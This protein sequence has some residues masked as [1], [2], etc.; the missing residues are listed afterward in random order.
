MKLLIIGGTRF[1]GRHIVECA[2]SRGHEITLFHRGHT[3]KDLFD[4]ESII[5]DRDGETDKLDARKWD[6]VIDTCGYVPRV[7][8]Q[9]AFILED[10]VDLYCFI[11][12]ISVYAEGQPTPITE[13]GQLIRF[14]DPP[15]SE[16]VTNETYGGFKVLCE[17]AVSRIV[18]EDRT[19]IVRPGLIVGPHDPTDRFTYWIDRYSS[20]REILVPNRAQQPMQFVDARDLAEF[21]V[22]LVEQKATGTYN[23]T[24]PAHATT[25]GEVWSVCK[26]NAGGLPEEVIVSDEFLAENEVKEWQDLP[27]ITPLGGDLTIVDITKSINAGL[28]IRPMAET[29]AATA[30]WHRTRGENPELKTGMTREREDELLG[31]WKAR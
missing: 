1:V 2:L 23:L 3:N 15:A 18:G 4:V 13:D 10:E 6:A 5:G 29:V 7:V 26:L 24:G 31:K 11:S 16:A 12:T 19:L 25:M 17:E 22:R 21:T 14:D 28:T 27:F 9:S 30:D 20:R 8:E